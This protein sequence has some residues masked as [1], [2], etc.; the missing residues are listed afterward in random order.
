MVAY[1]LQPKGIYCNIHTSQRAYMVTYT[2]EGMYVVVDSEGADV[3]AN[4]YI[5]KYDRVNR[6]DI[7]L[8]MHSRR[9]TK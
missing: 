2:S 9:Q 7:V 5:H 4:A 6:S 8:V 1:T 3:P